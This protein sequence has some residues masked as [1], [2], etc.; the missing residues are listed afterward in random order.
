MN[1][2]ILRE[3][4]R[5][6]KDN[7]PLEQDDLPNT[8]DRSHDTSIEEEEDTLRSAADNDLIIFR[9]IDASF[10][11][12]TLLTVMQEALH[13]RPHPLRDTLRFV[14]QVFQSRLGFHISE[15]AVVEIG[16]VMKTTPWPWTLSRTA[17][18]A[19]VSILADAMDSELHRGSLVDWEKLSEEDSE[20]SVSFAFIIS[21][22][23]PKDSIPSSFAH[24][25]EGINRHNTEDADLTSY[26]PL[27][28]FSYQ[29]RTL[30]QLDSRWPK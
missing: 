10:F 17:R 5:Y 30:V 4:S 26:N 8:Q 15:G 3:L 13:R 28:T 18:Y 9:N 2:R 24:L 6:T 29:M 11:D 14:A 16:P 21:L 12:D 27:D 19:L 7:T 22:L 1:L 23:D 20:W 25:F